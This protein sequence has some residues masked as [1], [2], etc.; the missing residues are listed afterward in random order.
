MPY[1]SSNFV[2][3]HEV[4]LPLLDALVSLGWNRDQIQCPSPDSDDREWRVPRNPSS[5]AR[6]EK[7]QRFDGFPVDVAIF[8][9][10]SDKGD[11]RHVSIIV[12]CK[13]PNETAGVSELETYLSLEPRA[14][15]GIWTNGS[16]VTRVYKLPSG[17]FRTVRNA[18]LPAPGDNL[19]LEENVGFDSL[20]VPSLAQLTHVFEDLL[21][22]IVAG[23]GRTTRADAR[24][25]QI[26]NL[27]LLKLNSDVLARS[28]RERS[29]RF[30]I[31]GTPQ[32]TAEAIDQQFAV[33][34]RDR[35]DLFS[36]DEQ[37]AILFDPAT[38]HAAVAELQRFDLVDVKPDSLSLAFQVFRSRNLKIGDGQY[39]TPSRVVS[40]AT[41]MMGIDI[42]NK[43]IDPAC[44]TGGFLSQAYL[45]VLECAGEADAVRWA[46]SH[47]FGVDRDDIN[48]KLARAL[49]VGLG[50]GSTNV[51]LGDSIRE[52]R[53][54]SYGHGLADALRD[55]SYDIVLTNPPFG[56]N[57][58]ITK[59]DASS[60][61]F[62]VCRHTPQG[63]DAQSYAPTELGIVFVER[64]Y[65]LLHVG[66]LLGIVLPET[67]FFS[68]TY[69]WFREWV[70][71]RFELKAVLNIPMEAFQGFCRAKTNFYVF[72]KKDPLTGEYPADRLPVWL[73]GSRTWVSYAPTIGIN[74]DGNELFCID[75]VT[76]RRTGEI[77]DVA[78]RDVT[79]L[80]SGSGETETSGFVETVPV[81]SSCIGVPRYCDRSSV[82]EFE[83]W[84]M[85]SLEGCEY[86]T[87]G[88]LCDV[89]KLSVRVGHGSPSADFRTGDV[90][91][92]K[93]SDLRNRQVNINKTNMVPRVVAEKFW[94][95]PASGIRAWDVITP[96]RAS[97]NIG[98]P[99]VVLPG[100]E[101]VVLTKEVL[102]LRA[103]DDSA[104]DGFYLAWALMLPKVQSQW[105]RVIFMQTNREDLGDRWREIEIPLPE[106]R[107]IADS[108]SKTARAY[109]TGLARLQSLLVNDLESWS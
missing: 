73:D 74:K 107:E 4:R 57:L 96:S 21:D 51:K 6:R 65:R 33:Y 71:E 29:V 8:D 3:H 69:S 61:A 43:V 101:D 59:S 82:E 86:D 9:S 105:E 15:L 62:S 52:S 44:G 97:K 93:V 58:K 2:E 26:C 83:N 78:L 103:E 99:V 25:N 70:D 37:D 12:E 80:I 1:E 75:A 87:L 42:D 13:A 79:N 14:R 18:S 49:M 39:F 35:R 95:G 20:S 47:L 92:I 41:Q 109:F 94:K 22:L 106:S 28:A 10:A 81:S 19:L 100:Q 88:H 60:G 85:S 24:L 31:K 16:L 66:G 91:Y 55:D 56:Q 72:V 68:S 76:H 98:E 50:D 32:E 84:V 63:R 53:W 64:A 104:F 90:P 7:G 102:V 27:L 11:Y 36:D 40:V 30:Q 38:I 67:Y 77:N 23:D 17:E 48:V 46:G 89:G 34:K 108:L 5:A 54:P 45:Q